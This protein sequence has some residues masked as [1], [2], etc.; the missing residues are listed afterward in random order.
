[1]WV[2]PLLM[3]ISG[4]VY[5][6][7][8]MSA[9]GGYFNPAVW[10]LPAIGVL[11]F[12]YFA[13]GTLAISAAWLIGRHF[14]MGCIG[15]GVLL[16][17]GP[18]FFDAMP[19]RFGNSAS[20]PANTFRMVTFN[21]LHL[22]DTKNPEAS[23]NRSLQ[24]LM[25]S[26]A[27]FICLQELY[28]V[29]DV[30]KKYPKQVE[31]MHSLYPYSTAGNREESFYSKYPFE[32]VDID[33]GDLKYYNIGAY[34]LRIDGN[35]L[36]V[37]NVHLPSYALSTEERRVITEAR[38]RSGVKKSIKELEGSVYQK[39]QKAFEERAVVSKAIADFAARQPGDVIVCGDFN[40]VPGSWTYRNFIK[41]G[42]EDA[43]AKTGFGHMITYNQHLMLFHIDQILYKGALTPLYVRK[44]R[45]DASDHYPLVA[46]FEFQ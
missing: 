46:E 33:L 20:N 14:I 25:D 29:N 26:E 10:T 43:Y 35:Q 3:V 1:M 9:Y 27:D 31:E 19:F 40:D 8:L 42:F 34:R 15:V 12:P 36:T 18:T 38:S 45:L 44:E 41:A 2:R 22:Q 21:C 17:C 6:I 4:L 11:F 32:L 37:I 39:M 16:A 13:M 23:S 28:T 7:T 5:F 24:F 30:Q